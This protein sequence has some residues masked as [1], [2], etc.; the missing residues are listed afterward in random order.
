MFLPSWHTENWR[1][2]Q[3]IFVTLTGRVPPLGRVDNAIRISGA[4]RAD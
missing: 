4:A 1:V 3:Q 2:L